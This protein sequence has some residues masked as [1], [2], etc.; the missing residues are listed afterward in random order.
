MSEWQRFFDREAATYGQHA[1]T[2]NTLAEVDFLIDVLDLAPGDRVLDIGCGTGRHSI[3]LARRGF[4]VTGLD[5]S[6]GMLD[7]ARRRAGEAG[8]DVNWVQADATRFSEPPS[9][10]ACICLCEGAFGLLGAEDDP[11]EQPLSILR[12][13]AQAL[14]PGGR[15]L[16]TV[17]NG[18][19]AARRVTR[20][21]ALSGAFDPHTMI[22]QTLC[23]DSD[24][25]CGSRLR[26]RG[27]VPTELILLFRQ[28]G[29]K[30]EEI[31]GGTAGGWRRAPVDVDEMEIM[32]VGRKDTP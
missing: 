2:H 3:E 12:N 16:F 21:E 7:E 30:V 4:R 9:F 23:C 31:W 8:V 20:E 29:L 25:G 17:L 26:E 11:I 18:I 14:R 1:F 15:C 5:I 22:E 10:D 13:A 28:A 19:A 6:E 32:V 27:F 24:S